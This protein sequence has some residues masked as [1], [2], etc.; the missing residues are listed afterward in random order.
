M[1]ESSNLYDTQPFH[2]YLMC[3]LDPRLDFQQSFFQG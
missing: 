1:Y 2:F 3:D